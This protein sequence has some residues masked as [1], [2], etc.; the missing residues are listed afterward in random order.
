MADNCTMAQM[1]QTPTEGYEDAIVIPEINA[2]FELKH[3]LINLVQNKQFFGHDKEDPHAHIRYFNKITS[4]MRFPDIPS[5]SIKLML[6]PFSLEG[7][8]WI[9]LEKEPPR[10]ILTWDDLVSK[11]IN[12]L[13]PPSKTTNLQTFYNAL[14]V[15]DQDSLNSAAGGN[16]LDKMP[17]ECL[18]SIESKS[19]TPQTEAKKTVQ[20]PIS[21]EPKSYQPKLPYP[22]RMKVREKDTPSAQQSSSSP[23]KTSDN[24]EEFA[25]E[26]TLLDSFLPGNDDS[27]LKKVVQEENF[28]VYSNPLFEFDDHFTSSNVD[29]SDPE[30]DID[31]IDAFLAMEVSSN[32]EEGYY[33]SERDVIFLKNLLSDDTTHNLAPE[34]IFDHE[35]KQNESI[36]NTSITFSPRN[37]PLHHEFAGEIITLPSRIASEH[38]EYLSLMTLLCEISTSRSPKNVHANPSSIIESLPV[39]LIPVEDSE[40]VQEEIDIFLVPDDLIPPGVENDDS[41]D[42]DNSTFLPDHELPNLDHQDNPS[43]PRPPPEPPDVKIR[44]EPDTAVTNNFDVLNKDACFNLEEGVQ[45]FLPFF[46][47]LEDSSFIFSLRSEDLV[48]DPDISTFHFSLKPVPFALPKDELNSGG[49][50]CQKPGHLAARLGCAETKVAT[51]DDLA[52]KLIILG[53]NVK[54]STDIAKLTRK[55]SKPDKHGHGKGK[56]NTRAGRMLSKEQS[57]I[58]ALRTYSERGI[59]IDEVFAPVARIEAIRIFLAYASYMGFTV[60]QMDVKS[61]FMYGQ[62][63]EEVYVCQPPGFEDPDHPNK[64]YKVVKALYGLH[65]APRACQDK[66][67]H[68]ILRKFNYSDVKSASTPTDLEKPLVQDGDADDVISW[69]CKKQTVGCPSTTEREYVAV[70]LQVAVDSDRFHQVI[71]FLT[72]SHI[73]YA[74]TKKPDVCVS[75]IKQFWGSAEVTTADNGEVKIIATIDGHSMTIMKF[76]TTDIQLGMI[77]MVPKK[78]AWEQFSSNIATAVICLATNRKYN[79]SRM[80]FEHMASNISSPHKFLMYPRIGALEVDLKKT[81]KT[82]SSAYTKLILRVKKLESQIKTGKAKEKKGSKKKQV[83]DFNQNIEPMDAEHES[84][85]KKSPEKEKS[86]EKIVEEEVVTQEEMKE[87]VKELRAKRKKSIPRKSTRKRQKMEEDGDEEE[88]QRVVA[89]SKSSK[90]IDWNDPLVI[91]YHT[92]KMKP[93]TVSQARQNMIK[94]LKNH[95][96]Y[97]IIDFKGMSYNDIRPILEK[98]WDFN[99]NIEPMEH[100]TETMKSPE[101]SLEKMKFGEKIEENDVVKE[102]GAKRKKSIPRKSIRK[103][104]KMENGLAIHM[105]TEKKYP[106]SQEMI[107]KMLKKKLEVDH[108]SSQAIELLRFIRS[109]VQK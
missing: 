102:P 63:E 28:Q 90:K 52:F 108:E 67:V 107:S 21:P 70:V 4:M 10:S 23:V 37:D 68:E 24:L 44:L 26:L 100:Q 38:E 56:E 86:P 83:W 82:Y 7:S 106:L 1:L 72:R 71:D 45:I 11:V 46:T 98:V 69:Q 61:A 75:F 3:G 74:L 59:A 30:V 96:N 73:C 55:R 85:K 65:Q 94:Y 17:R 51:W 16:F 19:K 93:K 34:V 31:E 84:E 22:E 39:S 91:R 77:R 109:Q 104:Q 18:R 35:P 40:P 47:Y 101:K 97:K 57:K 2:N 58:V 76:F 42:E 89:E 50:R 105:L 9:W 25:D 15:N 66:Y 14:N 41:E 54:H 32:F 27:I 13:F 53:W 5:T 33:D 20:E 78:T 80:I 79:F 6:F 64:V 29:V 103:R 60:Y 8:A 12:Q 87:V 62:I 48:F 49:S 92:L 36:H 95:R 99:Q 88:K 43:A 81:K